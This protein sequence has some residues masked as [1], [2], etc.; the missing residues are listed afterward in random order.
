MAVPNLKLINALRATS[1]RLRNGAHYAWG[2]HGSC[3]CGNLVQVISNFTEGEIIRYAHASAGEWTELA[4]EYCPITNVPFAL[5]MAKLEE[6]GLSS[7]D[8]HHIEYLNDKAVLNH[9]PNGFRW[10]QRN[11]REDVIAYFDAFSN[12]L[13]HQLL[14]NI[15]LNLE[16]FAKD[17]IDYEKEYLFV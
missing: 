3:N 14:D 11:V 5:V 15:E 4:E 8:I 10:L 17:D 12:M 6:I 13:E 2:H 7:A 16:Q 9:L 1:S